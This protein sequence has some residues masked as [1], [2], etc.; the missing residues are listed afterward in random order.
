MAEFKLGRIRFVWKDAWSS[1]NTY[2]Q[3]D[4]VSFGGKSY[5]CVLGHVSAGNFFDDL[6]VSPPK[7]NLVSD[8]QTWKGSWETGTEYVLDDIVRYGARLYIANTNHTSAATTLDG[9]EADQ[10]NWDIFAEGLE[11]RGD[12]S[13]ETRYIV[14]DIVKYGGKTYVCNTAHTSAPTQELG[15]EQDSANWDVFNSGLEY[16]STW[17]PGVRYRLN[18]I[19]QFGASL[20]IATTPHT[21][22]SS[23]IDNESNW[24]QF[25]QGFQFEDEWSPAVKYQRG[26][27]VRYGGYQYLAVENNISSNPLD[28]VSGDW[29]LFSKG[30]RFLGEFKEDSA[31]Q[32]Y[33]PGE[34]VSYGGYSY[35]CIKAHVDEDVEDPEFWQRLSTGI[36]WRGEWIDDQEYLLGDIVR[37]NTNNYVCVLTHVS[38][39]DDFSSGSPSGDPLT[40]LGSRPDQDVNGIYWALMTVGTE[41]GVLNTTGDLVFFSG[42]GPARLP[43]GAKGQVLRVSSDDL[44]EWA[45]LG[46]S[47]DVYYV[48]EHGENNPAPDNGITIDR[49][50]ASI[51]Y[52]CEQVEKGAKNPNARRLLELNRQF[53]QREI[54]EFTQFQITNDIAPFSSAFSFNT[55]KCQRDMGLIVDA[56]IHDV[57]HGGNVKS[58]EAALEYVNNAPQ[59]YTLG[60]EAETV[61]SI[62][63]GLEVLIN[64]LNQTDPD[65][66]YQQATGDNSTAIVPQFKD[67]SIVSEPGVVDTVTDLIKIITDAIL[68]GNADNIPRRIIRNTLIRVATGKFRE[69]LPI[70]VPAECC[71]I[72]DELRS[73]TV[74]ARTA[75]NSVLT[76]KSDVKFSYTGVERIE[77][78]IGDVVL[79]A[80]VTPSEGNLEFQDQDYPVAE[81]KEAD[82]VTQLARSIKRRID[83]GVGEKIEAIYPPPYVMTTPDLGHARDL[84]LKNRDFI[85]AEIIAFIKD[86]YPEIKYSRTKCKQDI[87][88]ILDAVA[89]DITFGG[90]S[91]SVVAGRAYFDGASGNL[92]IDSTEK[93][94]TIAAYNYLRDI[95]PLIGRNQVVVTPFQNTVEQV[96]GKGSDSAIGS[97]I[98]PLIDTITDIIDLGPE[99][100]EGGSPAVVTTFPD[101]SSVDA[102]LVSAS[103]ELLAAAAQIKSDTIVFITAN[104]PDLEYD[105]DKCQRDIGF[106]ID[107]ARFDWMLGTNAASLVAGYSYLRQQSKKVVGE[108]KAATLAANEYARTL[109]VENVEANATAIAGVN[110]TWQII[111][112]LIFTA[113][114]E[115]SLKSVDNFNAYSA[116]RQI[117][118]NKQFFIEEVFA[119]VDDVFSDTVSQTTQGT[120]AITITDTTWLSINDPVIF[121]TLEDSAD[122]ITATQGLTEDVVYFVKEIIDANNFTVAET[123]DG[124]EVVLTNAEGEFRVRNAYTYN[125]D[126]CARDVVAYLDAIKWDLQFPEQWKRTY[127]NNIQLNLPATYKSRLAARY[128]VN[129]VIGSQE[130]DMYYLRNGTGLRNQ[131]LD[132]LDGDLT[133]ANEFGTSRVTAGA[134]ASLDPGWGPDDERVWITARSPYVQNV[135][136]FGHAAVGQRIDGG[137]HNGGNDSI[138]SNDFTQV[139]SDGIG[140]HILNN[141]RAELVSVFT[142]YAHIGYLAESGGRIRATNGNNS[143][144]K[145]GSVAEG[146][147]VEEIPVTAVVDNKFQFNATISRVFTNGNQLLGV[148]Y[149][150]AGNEY[151]RAKINFFG[152]GVNEETVMDDFRDDAVFQSRLIRDPSD[153]EVELG[154]EGYT[155]VRNT[156]QTG[157]TTSITLAATDGAESTAYPGMSVYVTGGA[158]AGQYGIIDDYNSGTKL[159]NVVR[160]TDGNP[161]WD[162][163]VPGT[164]IVSPNASSTYQVEPTVTFQAPVNTSTAVSLPNSNTWRVVDY[165]TT[166]EIYTSVTGASTEDGTGAEFE[167]TRS[168]SKYSVDLTNSG[169]GYSRLETI[170]LL[171][172]NLGGLDGTH[173]IVVTI[174][175]VNSQGEVVAF[176]FDG[177]G[178]SGL[179]IA[180]GAGQGTANTSFD[181]ENWTLATGFGT[182]VGNVVDIATGVVDDFST[183]FNPS[184]AVLVSQAT[185]TITRTSD[186]VNWEV[187]SLPTNFVTDGTPRIA[188][189]QP[190]LGIGRFVVT[191]SENRNVAYSDDGGAT[192]TQVTNALPA[193]VNSG[194]IK[195][196]AFGKGLYVVIEK[197]SDAA[198]WSEDGITWNLANGHSTSEWEDIAYG[199]NRFVAISS[200]G[201]DGAYSIDGKN[202]TEVT[203]PSIDGSSVNN[204]QRIAYGQGVFVATSDNVS[205]AQNYNTVSYSEDGVYWQT[206]GIVANTGGRLSA[207][208]FGNPESKGQFVAIQA[209]S[210]AQA[211]KI[212]IGARAKGRVSVANEQVFEIRLLD[213]GSAYDFEPSVTI[214][215]PSNTQDAVFQNRVGIGVLSQPSFISR[216]AGYQESSAEVDALVSNGFADFFQTGDFV[217]VRRLSRRPIPGSNVVFANDPDTVFKLVNTVSFLGVDNGS[218]TAFIQISPSIQVGE[219]PEHGEDIETR[220]R[221]SQVRLTG[222]DFLDIGTGNFE[223]TNYPGIPLIEPDPDKETVDNDGGR[224]FFT[225][226]DQDGNFRV[227]PVFSVEQAT[228]IATLDAQAFNIA[229]LQELSLGEVTLG[230]NSASITEFSTDPFFTA[231]SDS[232]VPTQRAIKAYIESQIG[233]GGASLNV[234]TVTAGDIFIGT[235][236]I[237]T[238]SGGTINI[239]ARLNFTKTVTGLPIAYNYF[240]R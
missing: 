179:F 84:I 186:G 195:P 44:P 3:D 224:V 107:A 100:L 82:A 174:T 57:T 130:E 131:T 71:V 108:Q 46:V 43:I 22:T 208:G 8:G 106:I 29:T 211:V 122:A 78:I 126:L 10:A 64:V 123:V 239:N 127:T 59:F 118:L 134:Y 187:D 161:G 202:W 20:W 188:F 198:A 69:T 206:Q 190:A 25:V 85:K 136:T 182:S 94:A 226:T 113:T 37:F 36:R 58:R 70:I 143:Y 76:P 129:S 135:T 170:T 49:P 124:V 99:S 45:Y 116:I 149:G 203:V 236:V 146:V 41:I 105:Q 191:C 207:I 165:L 169:I 167:V 89:Y 98:Q 227:G 163:V 61:A 215:D 145:F 194:D 192:W 233:G 7:W 152:P 87:G 81:Q 237:S 103:D 156:A 219:E 15:L 30:I 139:I 55:N 148:E 14:N 39:G 151:T 171:G 26:D 110:R 52:A 38:E 153:P 97:V 189:G 185:T 91:Q 62:N 204:Y 4:V 72:G 231:N 117:E 209:S 177:R 112:D 214:T 234:N 229:G 184:F 142:Y 1:G 17:V 181:G 93:T 180:A 66:N 141:G 109:A 159:A 88:F 125:K 63:Y 222:H 96:R 90:N 221:F 197:S 73:T 75:E 24:E 216:G 67:L 33:L 196:I 102:A 144:G 115:A 50:W 47:E 232:V 68:A 19:V 140:A 150:H 48:A 40:G 28:E 34:L 218:F 128:Y 172:S 133:P 147:D 13:V 42:N 183:D 121:Q 119:Y 166:S 5:I 160:A 157:T 104:F 53:V 79:G 80:A 155:V 60:Q 132:G 65:V 51:R 223:S 213:P 23:F 205:A 6:F 95:L 200:S 217:A 56:L 173:D 154:G 220:I 12:W 225:A 92:Q 137:L 168:G 199:N 31:G 212:R 240:L 210:G 11:W 175:T 230:G 2:F 164:T 77:Q 114:A 176:D 35:I 83:F 27:V 111:N 86:G 74:K 228:G 158:G 101:T 16:R 32:E 193:E 120:N 235:N 21:S 9:L 18:D 238:A 54:L 138:V 178:R 162:H 201:N